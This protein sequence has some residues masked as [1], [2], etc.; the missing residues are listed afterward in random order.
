MECNLTH[1]VPRPAHGGLPAE[2]RKRQLSAMQF[3]KCPVEF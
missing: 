1:P 2:A 3:S